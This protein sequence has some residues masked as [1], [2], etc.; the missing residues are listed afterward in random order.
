VIFELAAVAIG[1]VAFCYA[2]ALAGLIQ[3]LWE[4]IRNDTH[5]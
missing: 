5:D 2:C 4:N 1:F 3:E